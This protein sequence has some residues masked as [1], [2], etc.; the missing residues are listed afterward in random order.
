MVTS[1]QKYIDRLVEITDKK[2][3]QLEEILRITND[4]T[5]CINTDGISGLEKLIE[6]KQQV[7]DNINKL[8]DE[9][10]VYFVRLKSVIKVNS[11]DEIKNQ[12]IP[13]TDILK[14]SVGRVLGILAQIDQIEKTN[15]QNAKKVLID[16][17]NDIKTL[18]IGKRANNAYIPKQSQVESYFFD[19]KK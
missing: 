16:I 4:Q 9:F 7:I 3:A 11:L 12:K 18:N 2:Y 15:N 14:N 6:A 5:A 17:G 10:E 8:D 13:G 19:K 1:P